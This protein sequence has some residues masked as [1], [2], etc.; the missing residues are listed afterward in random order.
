[1]TLDLNDPKDLTMDRVKQFIASCDDSVH[2][3]IRVTQGGIAFISDSVGATHTEGIAFRLE[4]CIG[5]NDYFGQKASQ[6]AEWVERIQAVLKKNWPQP[7]SSYID[8]F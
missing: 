5:G 4:T 6:D 2:R 7:S 1:M 8:E 3:Q